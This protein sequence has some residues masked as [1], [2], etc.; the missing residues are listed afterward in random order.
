MKER[1]IIEKICETLRYL[2][3]SFLDNSSSQIDNAFFFL[4]RNFISD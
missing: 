2:K 1:G 4:F 3:N